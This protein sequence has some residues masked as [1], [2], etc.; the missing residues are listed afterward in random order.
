MV[1]SLVNVG[2]LINPLLFE[3]NVSRST[4]YYTFNS[5]NHGCEQ[6]TYFGRKNMKSLQ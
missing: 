1:S 5:A 3:T 6:T 4:E 2:H